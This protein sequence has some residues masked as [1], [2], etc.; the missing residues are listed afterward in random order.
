M[1]RSSDRGGA[2]LRAESGPAAAGPAGAR[3]GILRP[4]FVYAAAI[5]TGV[6]LEIAWPLS[7]VPRPL[8]RP[9]GGALALAALVLL[10]AAIGQLRAA[11]TPVPG[12]R[13]TTILVRTGPYRLSRNP[14]YLAF[15]LLHLGGAIWIG[16]WWLLV[17]LVASVTFI[18]AVVVRREERYL[19]ERFG[20]AYLA[21]KASVRRWL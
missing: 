20:T 4:P 16:S 17:T 8:A 7:F 3:A 18:V 19:Q 2:R 9:V 5:L 13:P 6:V 11:G 10:M 15:S 1:E 12:H 14:I 21:Y